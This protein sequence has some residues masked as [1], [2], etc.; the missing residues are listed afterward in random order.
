MAQE[1]GEFDS[2]PTGEDRGYQGPNQA[3]KDAGKK[4]SP[5]RQ[6]GTGSQRTPSHC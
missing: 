3:N 2:N 4:Q 6:A 5:V 1:A